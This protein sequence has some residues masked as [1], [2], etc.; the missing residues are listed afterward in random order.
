MRLRQAITVS[1]EMP[2]RSAI[3]V[4]ATPRTARGAGGGAGPGSAAAAADPLAVAGASTL[5]HA[6][7]A[8]IAVTSARRGPDGKVGA[9]VMVAAQRL[10]PL[11]YLP[12]RIRWHAD[13][14][15]HARLGSFIW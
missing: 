2:S 3:L 9:D 11:A 6:A 7:D 8:A 1:R 12:D 5:F 15:E 14:W 4:V 10:E 13:R